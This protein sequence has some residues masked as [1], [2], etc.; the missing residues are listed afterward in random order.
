M[1]AASRVQD[2]AAETRN[3]GEPA[4]PFGSSEHTS[5]PEPRGPLMSPGYWLHHAAL[6]WRQVGTAGHGGPRSGEPAARPADGRVK[7]LRLTLE[8]RDLVRRGIRVAVDLD[9]E[10]FGAAG[11][12][13]REILQHIAATARATS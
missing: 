11:D 10:I 1:A 9:E 2:G 7:R 12:P 13:L 6:A 5:H 8:G 3:R 4:D